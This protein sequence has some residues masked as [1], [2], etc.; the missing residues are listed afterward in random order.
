MT[1]K[2]YDAIISEPSNPWIAGE[3]A[4]FTKEYFELARDHLT[5]DGV[6]CFWVQGYDISSDEFTMLMRT[7]QSVF[8][9]ATLWEPLNTADYMFVGSLAPIKLDITNLQ[10][11]IRQPKVSEDLK[12]VYVSNAAEFFSKFI[13]GPV[14]FKKVAG[15]GEIHTDDK[16]QLEYQAPR[17]LYYTSNFYPELYRKIIGEK[18]KPRVII[19]PEEKDWPP[20]F[21]NALSKE[22]LAAELVQ[23]GQ[24][25]RI[26]GPLLT[27]FENIEMAILLSPDN[28]W[29]KELVGMICDTLMD[30]YMKRDMIKEAVEM[31]RKSAELNPKSASVLDNL[32]TALFHAGKYE[33]ARTEFTKAIEIEADNFTAIHYIGDIDLREGNIQSAKDMFRRAID[34]NPYYSPPFVGLGLV[35]EA[36]KNY[37]GAQDN[38]RKAIKLDPKNAV[39]YAQLGKLLLSPEGGNKRKSGTCYLEK[40]FTL[41]PKLKYNTEFR[42]LLEE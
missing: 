9:E 19:S 11:R 17:H 15:E 30:Y 22:M 6:F 10:S 26:E 7:F 21:K 25:Y 5:P 40:A 24:Y 8:P 33:E 20:D 36:Q 34:L 2:R 4:L 29:Y 27:A 41:D 32:G 39:A 35:A 1:R 16:L 38:F 18:D 14:S 31:C 12:R 28:G 3:S 42:G 23:S 37:K 13:M